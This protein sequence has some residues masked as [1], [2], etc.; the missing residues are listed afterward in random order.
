MTALPPARSKP[1]HY[2]A[3]PDIDLPEDKAGPPFADLNACSS[4]RRAI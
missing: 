2:P 3:D 4:G 1:T